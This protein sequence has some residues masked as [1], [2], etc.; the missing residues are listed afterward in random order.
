MGKA[1]R[2]K[3][4]FGRHSRSKTNVLSLAGNADFRKAEAIEKINEVMDEI[5]AEIY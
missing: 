2:R 1:R 4:F 5:R 3:R